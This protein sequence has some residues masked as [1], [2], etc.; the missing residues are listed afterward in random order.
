MMAS[1]RKERNLVEQDCTSNCQKKYLGTD[2]LLGQYI[3]SLKN[4]ST[5]ECNQNI[6]WV[7]FIGS[8][9]S[10][11]QFPQNNF[12]LVKFQQN[13]SQF[14]KGD[15]PQYRYSSKV[16]YYLVFKVAL[17]A[18]LV[19]LLIFVASGKRLGKENLTSGESQPQKQGNGNRC[20]PF[21][22]PR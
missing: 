15:G 6:N 22:K 12:F 1:M 9:V 10:R 17:W 16:E 18:C 11:T 13:I 5:G 4:D 20:S 14:L 2:T 8:I 21:P 7:Y 3:C 19:S